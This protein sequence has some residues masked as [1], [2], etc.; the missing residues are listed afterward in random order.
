MI[1]SDQITSTFW[2]SRLGV[3]GEIVEDAN[4]I[5]QAIIIILTTP[6]GSDPHRP[7]FAS[8]IWRHIDKP[9]PAAAP[10]VVRDAAEAIAKWEPR[11]EVT[12]VEVFPYE[13]PERQTLRVRVSWK[14]PGTGFEDSTEVVL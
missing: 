8:N 14:I 3:M 12:S 11:C 7:D 1:R 13:G 10:L 6:K 5:N 4:D 2:Q 9:I